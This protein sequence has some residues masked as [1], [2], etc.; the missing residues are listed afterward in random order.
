M[1]IE[2]NSHTVD[3][4]INCDATLENNMDFAQNLIELS[5]NLA[6]PPLSIYPENKNSNLKKYVHP[7]IHS[8]I[9]Y[10]CQD[11]EANCVHQQMNE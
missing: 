2:R 5:N 9:I 3:G 6:T 10:S 11:T 1:R 7:N 8:S 4:K